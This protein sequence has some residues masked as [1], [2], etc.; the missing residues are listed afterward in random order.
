MAFGQGI[1]DSSFY[2]TLEKFNKILKMQQPK[3]LALKAD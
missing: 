3:K 1:H 2:H